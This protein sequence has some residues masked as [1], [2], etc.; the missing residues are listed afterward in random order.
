MSFRRTARGLKLGLRALTAANETHLAPAHLSMSAHSKC[1]LSPMHQAEIIVLLLTAV[2]VLAVL[3]YKLSLPYP[4]VLVLGGLALSFVPRLPAVNLN[5]DVVFY[6]ILPA[7]IYPAALFTSWRDFRRNLRPILLLAI[8]LVLATTL[9]VAWVAHSTV[10][11]LPWAAAFALGAIV[12]PPDAVAATAIIRRLSVPHRIQVILEGESL[13]NDA[14][15]LVT[16][17]FAIAALV[18]GA[19]SP[20]YAAGRFVWAAAAGIGIGLAVAVAMRWVHSHLDNPP[21]QITFSLLTPFIAYLPAEQ[22]HASGVLAAVAA[23]I[24]L[25]WHSPLMITARTR[26]QAYAFWETIVFL[27]NGFVFI[28][29]GLQLP[30]ILHASN[31][32]SLTRVFVSAIVICATVVLVRFAWVIPGS[33][34]SRLLRNERQIREPIPSWQEVAILGWSGMRGVVSLAAAFALPLALTTGQ[35]FPG[36][37]YILFVA[38]SVILVTLVLQGLTL[39]VLI[40][41]LNVP[42]DAETDE[43]ERLA[44]LEANKAAVRW[45]EEANANGKFSPEA[46]NRLHAE[47]DERIQQLELCGQNPDDC[48][49]EIATPQYQRLQ[50]QALGVER[51]TIIR[52]RNERVINDDALRRIQRDLDLAEARLTGD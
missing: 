47:Y 46:A 39:P 26:L 15:A 43:E 17:Q 40:R 38:F 50:H 31:H 18:T 49:G 7:L 36:R 33:Y 32:E 14:T 19:F 5:P 2:G 22:V 27:L 4:I 21:I 37:D 8:G 16:L 34:L 23:G 30:R 45:I 44:R 24:F 3:A 51:K 28:V 13:V 20:A 52:L 48:R 11:T 35:P 42:A 12:S 10:P 41:K 6:F 25:G 1:S 9:A 29:I